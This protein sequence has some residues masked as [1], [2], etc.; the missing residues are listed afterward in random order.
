MGAALKVFLIGAVTAIIILGAQTIATLMNTI[1]N[2][3]FTNTWMIV[4]IGILTLV[5]IPFAL[6]VKSD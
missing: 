4:T 5:S 2:P 3:F 1:E 6:K